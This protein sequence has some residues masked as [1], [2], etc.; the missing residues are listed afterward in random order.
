MDTV[1]DRL[2]QRHG[3][4]SI[5]FFPARDEA[6]EEQLRRAARQIEPL[7]PAFVTITYGAGG[8]S[9]DRTVSTVGWLAEQTGLHLV[10][11]LAAVGH[12]VAD[13]RNVVGHYAACGVR[14][15]LAIRGDPPGDPDGEWIARPDGVTYASDL[16]R[17]LH[18]M[19]PF[20]V[21]VA[22]FPYGHPRSADLDADTRHL[23]EKIEAGAEYVI[24]QLFFEAEDYLRLRDRLAAHG[25]TVPVIPGVMPLTTP[26]ALDKAVEL[27]GARH[28]PAA[29]SQLLAYGD[30]APTFRKAGIDFTTRLCA[31]L[32]DEEVP[33][34]HFYSLNR[35]TAMTQVLRRL[36]MASP[37]SL[38]RRSCSA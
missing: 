16:V 13:L 2:G 8:S 36:G 38:S 9:R 19:G 24:A 27:S 32:L 30:S 20:C 7:D 4:F 18:D 35:T 12:S 22:G 28:R 34:L 31:R 10:G 1:I 17:I 14:S 15:V 6:G 21:G 11:H 5:E 3:G 26:R 33:L 23:L 25:C 37:R 29:V